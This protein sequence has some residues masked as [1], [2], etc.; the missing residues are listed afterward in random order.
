MGSD[1][2]MK[3]MSEASEILNDLNVPFE[4]TIVSAHRTPHRMVEYA[5]KAKETVAKRFNSWENGNIEEAQMP[6]AQKN[7]EQL[8]INFIDMPNAV[9]SNISLRMDG[10]RKEYLLTL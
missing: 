6:V 2:D 1:S 7:P 5:E 3:V 4:M 10:R 9:Q 8:T